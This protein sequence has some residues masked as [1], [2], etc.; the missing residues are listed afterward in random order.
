MLRTTNLRLLSPI[1]LAGI[2]LVNDHPA[3]AQA[4]A[5]PAEAQPAPQQQPQ[6]LSDQDIQ[7]LRKNLRSERK[8][9]IAANL[10]LTDTEAEKFWPVYEQYVSELVAINN[11]KYDL[12]KQYVQGN[13]TLTDAQAELAVKQWIGV[14]QSVGTL[15]LKYVPQFRKVLSPKNTA[16]FYQLDRRIQLM[17][18]LQLASALPLIEP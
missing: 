5:A 17:I 11:T 16:L 1:L 9:V 4:A 18:D 12:I 3:S 8:Q 15:R 13:G 10:K 7:L 2:L 14:D 6:P